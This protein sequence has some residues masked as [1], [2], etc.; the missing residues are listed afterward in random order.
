MVNLSAPRATA[1]SLMTKQKHPF[2]RRST[3][4]GSGGV[5]YLGWHFTPS[6]VSAI[7]NAVVRSA[8]ALF[9]P[10]RPW[11][12]LPRIRLS[13]HRGWPVRQATPYVG[14]V[15]AFT[16]KLTSE[17]LCRDRINSD[18]VREREES[19]MMGLDVAL[20][21]NVQL[22]GLRGWLPHKAMPGQ[23]ARKLVALDRFRQLSPRPNTRSRIRGIPSPMSL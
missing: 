3:A 12:A 20:P 7:T 4:V 15:R 16:S 18:A 10:R 9:Q 13:G 1:W 14:N 21:Q 19:M 23:F 22:A 6:S 11:S 17:E 5:F 2:H 8:V